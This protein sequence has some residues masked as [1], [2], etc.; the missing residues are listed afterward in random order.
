M[1]EK[2]I[3]CP[4]CGQSVHLDARICEHCG[5]NLALAALLAE[6]DIGTL[7]KEEIDV[8]ITPEILVPRLGDYLIEKGV[9]S[10]K[11]L[12]RALD[13]KKRQEKKGRPL[14]IGQALLELGLIG[15]ETLDQV[16]TEQ[17]LQLQS[18]LKQANAELEDRVRERTI[19]LENALNR[20]GEL[21]RLKSNFIANISHELRTPLTHI[22]GYIELLIDGLGPL[23][24]QQKN[25][26]VVMK[27]SEERLEHLIEDLIQFSLLD[28]GD[29]DLAIEPVDLQEI[30]DEVIMG[31]LKECSE[32]KISLRPR[33]PKKL[34][35]VQAD[36]MKI[37]WVLSELINNAIKFSPGGGV[38]ELGAKP[39]RKRVTLYV[40]DNGIGIDPQ[41]VSEIFEPFHQLDGS[42]TRRFGG[43]GLGLTMVRQI[44]E[45]HGSTIRVKSKPGKGS[46]FEFSLEIVRT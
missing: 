41:K 3:S 15:R 22:K 20:L 16:I 39:G 24:P 7:P 23:T 30:I 31:A 45:A 32:A 21:N 4:Q 2:L 10:R 44:V 33:M 42:A 19:E 34:P 43:T 46:Q 26:L 17:I 27:K 36:R 14:L 8:P 35:T 40:K 28:R 13:F 1:V 38:V 29:V 25:A 18:A 11:E 6:R 9:L 37:S 5:V 12:Q